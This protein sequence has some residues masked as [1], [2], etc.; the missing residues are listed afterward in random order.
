MISLFAFII[1]TGII[2]DDAIIVSEHV[3]HKI[4]GGEKPLP[5]AITGAREMAMPVAFAILTNIAAFVPLLFV[6]GVAGKIFRIIPIVVISVMLFS[7]GEAFFILPAHIVHASG[8][9]PVWLRPMQRV[10]RGADAAMRWT[11]DRVYRP[12]LAAALSWKYLIMATALALL[13]MTT[14]LV[15][16]GLLPFDFFPKIESD[17]VAAVI[18]FPEG[19]PSRVVEKAKSQVETAAFAALDALDARNALRGMLTR[20]GEVPATSHRL[21]RRGNN[22]ASVELSLVPGAERA[23]SVAEL[24]AEWQRATPDIAGID[25]VK[26][27]SSFGPSAGADIDVLLIHRDTDALSAVSQQVEDYLRSL[28]EAVNVESTWS[29]GRPEL[30]FTLRPEARLMGLTASD[31][32]SQLRGSFYGAEAFRRQ[33]GRDEVKVMVRLPEDQRQS[34]Q[35]LA[36][37]RVRTPAGG[38]VP[39]SSVATYRLGRAPER[40]NRRDGRR[41]VNV[42]ASLAKGVPSPRPLLAGIKRD[43]LTP[44]EERYP[45]LATTFMGSERARKE[46]FDSLG[47]NFAV[48]LF[49]MF[50]LLAVPFRSYIQP[51]IIMTVIPFGAVGAVAGH[52]IMGYD[53]SI[54]SVLGVIALS[55]VVVNDALILIDTTNHYRRKPGISLKEAISE[56]GADRLRPIF[57]TSIT[58]FVGLVPLIF[59]TSPQARLLVPMVI[60]LGFGVLFSSFVALL[61]VPC[62]YLVLEDIRHFFGV[63][64]SHAETPVKSLPV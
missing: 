49:V 37:L 56:A 29:E 18:R 39:L 34:E 44:L 40:I 47:V 52:L 55:G 38:L 25:S 35:D 20:I 46:A 6:P 51:S 15:V 26:F 62:L 22:L 43:V 8:K 27:E 19:I 31:V 11:I 5:A 60:S 10:R 58:T 12:S 57:L 14:A 61:L 1:T 9:Q 48:A 3:F 63:R 53:L 16:T 28:P 54:I 23:F 30:N 33:Q 42:T 13:V 32:A 59:E 4:Q 21:N 2:V 64:D 17:Q 45:G 24:A 41:T 50:A 7:L 36:A